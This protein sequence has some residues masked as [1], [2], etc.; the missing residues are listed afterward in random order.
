MV[1]EGFLSPSCHI[2]IGMK[3][4]VKKGFECHWDVHCEC[5]RVIVTP[6]VYAM[7]AWKCARGCVCVCVC[8]CV[9]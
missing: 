5:V 8:V 3:A 6:F 1:W 2:I 4:S 9:C 7:C